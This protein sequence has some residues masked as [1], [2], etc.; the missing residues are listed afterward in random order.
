MS[1][2]SNSNS[3]S[4]SNTNT[5]TSNNSTAI[6]AVS[7][8]RKNTCSNRN[9]EYDT[10][11]GLS[12]KR[13]I[14]PDQKYCWQHQIMVNL[15]EAT[16][17]TQCPS[18]TFDLIQEIVQGAQEIVNNTSPSDYLIFIGQS[19]HYLYPLVRLQRNAIAVPISGLWISY[20][21]RDRSEKNTVKLD[22][23]CCLL[24]SLGLTKQILEEKRIIMI[25]H[26]HSGI[27]I[28]DYAELLLRC[29]GYINRDSITSYS[30]FDHRIRFINIISP[31]QLRSKIIKYPNHVV[32]TILY[33]L[34][35]HLVQ[36]ANSEYPR[37]IP[38][39]AYDKWDEDPQ[40]SSYN[41]SIQAQECIN[42]ITMVG[43]FIQKYQELCTVLSDDT[44]IIELKKIKTY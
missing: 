31:L 11:V 14:K 18:L 21:M 40:F 10:K 32:K 27:S 2:S 20:N 36:F 13:I 35:P 38:S 6:S 34:M 1:S 26:S 28:S 16:A 24:E 8:P 37:T 33:L 30:K 42:K 19:P 5:N 12:C 29:F 7:D 41:E 25:D 15:D 44:D 3:N 43:H 17:L 4:N 9:C 39:Y 23:Y 22:K